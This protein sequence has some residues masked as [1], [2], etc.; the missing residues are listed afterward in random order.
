MARSFFRRFCAVLTTGCALCV[1]TSDR[2]CAADD[3][4]FVEIFDEKTL[5]GWDGNPKFWSV[6]DGAITGQTT[7]DNKTDGNTF[8]IWRKGE[9]GDFELK[10]E[11][12]I[13]NGNSGIQYRSQEMGDKKW[14]IGGYQG[15]FEAGDTYSGI[16]Y[17]ERGRGILA[18][19][20]QKTVIHENGKPEVVEKIGETK[21]LQ[22]H[23]KKEDWNE[24]H[25]TAKGF[26]FTH[27]INGHVTSIV[28]DEDTSDREAKGLLALQLHAGPAMTV[29]FRNIRLKDL[30]GKGDNAGSK[31]QS[32]LEI[33]RDGT[34]VLN[35]QRVKPEDISDRLVAARKTSE[36][37]IVVA[38]P[39][40]PFEDVQRMIE[41][42]RI[43]GFGLFSLKAEL[44]KRIVFIAGRQSHGYG[45]HE[46]KAGCM[47]LQKELEASGLPIETTLVTNG[48][49]K[50]ESV[51]DGADAI[52]IYADGG[53]GHP[54]VAHLDT[55]K[56]L[57]D[58]GV[59]I[60]C[61]HY[62]VE[63]PKGEAGDAFLDAIGGYFEPHWSVNPHWTANYKALPQHPITRGIEPFKIQ[64][65]WYYHMRFREGMEGVTPILTD[66]PPA[67]SLSRPDGPHE[68]NPA[69]RKAIANGEPQHMAWAYERPN[70]SRGFGFTGAHFH[71]NWG[72]DEFRQLVLNA[73]V[74]SAGLDVPKEGVPV[75]PLTVADLEA[76]QDEDKPADYNPARIAAMLK[77][78]NR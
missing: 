50:D 36:S 24:Y 70:G 75:Q 7:D 23:I 26:T 53:G 3:D 78:W 38:A 21:E 9:V 55:L 31:K 41:E 74:W 5:D 33:R 47:L 30:S 58:R 10:L 76:N 17:D 19:R 68:G 40:V 46:H 44:P 14:V 39:D 57:A 71:W 35:G 11:Y 52:V 2:A 73:V 69:V 56:K 27:A 61:L 59:G 43:A 51:L 64:D 62:G 49:P 8:I 54:A 6:R 72:N 22:S 1:V 18:Q 28:T 65:E 12:K 77:E 29:Q 25:I 4:G 37:V 42:G 67:E 13:V 63:V 15:D 60:V 66:L 20:G 45:A 34:F 48:W 16:N 32:R